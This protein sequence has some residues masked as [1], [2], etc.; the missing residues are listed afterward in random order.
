[1]G[2]QISY[3]DG[4]VYY[5][6]RDF[7]EGGYFDE[8]LGRWVE[9]GGE[10]GEIRAAQALNLHELQGAELVCETSDLSEVMCDVIP[11]CEWDAGQCWSSVGSAPCESA[12][13]DSF[14]ST[15]YSEGPQTET[16]YSSGGT[17]YSYSSGGTSYSYSSGGTSYSYSSEESSY[18]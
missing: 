11:C 6:D 16:S 13:D 7:N 2:E 15:T 18:S 12:G 14:S 4:D 17:S 8:G 9:Y 3:W 1:M 5:G 10:I